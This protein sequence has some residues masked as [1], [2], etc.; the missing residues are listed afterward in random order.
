M[1]GV[2]LYEVP[3]MHPYP[4][5]LDTR[6]VVTPGSCDCN[7]ARGGFCG[8]EGLLIWVL[9]TWVDLVCKNL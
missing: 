4:V 6:A 5:L 2:H 9:V 8:A 7:G 1:A 3:S